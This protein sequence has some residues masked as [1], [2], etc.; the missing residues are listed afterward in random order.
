MN[1]SCDKSKKIEIKLSKA[2]PVS[3][4]P[5]N[6]AQKAADLENQNSSKLAANAKNEDRNLF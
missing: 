3:K 5:L 2:Q 1:S 4:K 6:D